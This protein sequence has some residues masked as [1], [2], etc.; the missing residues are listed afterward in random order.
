MYLTVLLLLLLEETNCR[1]LSCMRL[2]LSVS[3][4]LKSSV[5]KLIA[6]LFPINPEEDK[7]FG[8]L[9]SLLTSWS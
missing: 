6:N 1:S 2:N 8:F 9:S 5:V 4:S 3:T 7:S